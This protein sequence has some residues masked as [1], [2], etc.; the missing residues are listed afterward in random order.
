TI[1]RMHEGVTAGVHDW[2]DS[3][4]YSMKRETEAL[5]SPAQI[6]GL[7]SLTGYLKSENHVVKFQ[8]RPDPQPDKVAGFFPRSSPRTTNVPRRVASEDKRVEQTGPV[9]KD[10]QQSIAPES[11]PAKGVDLK[12]WE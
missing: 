9:V 10:K 2:R 4:N 3:A 11:A 8:F 1:E 7:P 12:I 6:T 5:I